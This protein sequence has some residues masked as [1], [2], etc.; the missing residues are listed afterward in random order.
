[1]FLKTTSITKTPCHEHFFTSLLLCLDANLPSYPIRSA[2]KPDQTV[3]AL[4]PTT[5][6][7]VP[8]PQSRNDIPLVSTHARRNRLVA[9]VVAL[10]WVGAMIHRYGKDRSC[11]YSSDE[12]GFA[13]AA[14]VVASLLVAEEYQRLVPHQNTHSPKTWRRCNFERRGSEFDW[15]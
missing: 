9:F 3:L 2:N 1:M 4:F 15:T 11:Y 8:N 14:L 10:V 13:S 6:T 12:Y 5:R 7:V